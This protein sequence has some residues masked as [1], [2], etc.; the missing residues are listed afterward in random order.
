ML[1]CWIQSGPNLV[2]MKQTNPNPMRLSDL[3]CIMYSV[4]E[5]SYS[6]IKSDS[7]DHQ[8]PTGEKLS[9]RVRV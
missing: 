1:V 3:D 6:I 5:C 8:I 2:Q 7:A 9:M 4:I